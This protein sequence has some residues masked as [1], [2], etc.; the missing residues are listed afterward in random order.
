VDYL[1]WLADEEFPAKVTIL[2]DRGTPRHYPVE[3][4]ANSVNLLTRRLIDAAREERP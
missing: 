4:V 2:L 3:G 1:L